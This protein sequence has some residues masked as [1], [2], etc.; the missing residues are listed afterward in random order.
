[1]LDDITHTN[2]VHHTIRLL[3]VPATKHKAHFA[4]GVA[5][6]EVDDGAEAPM[7]I[8]VLDDVLESSNLNLSHVAFQQTILQT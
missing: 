6:A 5:L 1:M 7:R 2:H 3:V 8:F 4:L